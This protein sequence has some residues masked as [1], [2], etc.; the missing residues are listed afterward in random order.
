MDVWVAVGVEDS[1]GWVLVGVD[2]V[3]G[4]VDL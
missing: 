4:V 3:V 1:C 2:V